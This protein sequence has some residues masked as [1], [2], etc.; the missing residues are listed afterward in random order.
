MTAEEFEQRH[1]DRVGLSVATLR[2]LGYVVIPCRCGEEICEG[3][4]SISTDLAAD[5]FIRREVVPD[6]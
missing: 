4:Q 3:W 1:A 5:P 6:P 2:R